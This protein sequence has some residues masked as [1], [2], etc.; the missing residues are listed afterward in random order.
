MEREWLHWRIESMRNCVTAAIF[1]PTNCIKV[2]KKLLLIS[3][4]ISLCS[5]NFFYDCCWCCCCRCVCRV[6][7]LV[8]II[9]CVNFRLELL[10]NTRKMQARTRATKRAK[11]G[12]AAT[13]QWWKRK[14]SAKR[15]VE[16]G[17]LKRESSAQYLDWVQ[18]VLNSS[19]V[20]YRLHAKNF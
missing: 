10:R 3:F 17:K 15:W 4:L 14:T 1:A 12:A 5:A 8:F 13:S 20:I 2:M 11:S 16:E 19:F 9:R 6:L 18:N 7:C